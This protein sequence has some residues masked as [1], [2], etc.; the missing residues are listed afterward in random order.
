MFPEEEEEK[1]YAFEQE[2]DE[3]ETRAFGE[4]PPRQLR[5]FVEVHNCIYKI[6]Y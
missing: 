3:K 5:R 4:E 2:E 1:T 6:K